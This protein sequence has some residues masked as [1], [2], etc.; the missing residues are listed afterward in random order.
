MLLGSDCHSH[1]ARVCSAQRIWG[2]RCHNKVVL[3]AWVFFCG[4]H[5]G[6]SGVVRTWLGFAVI[7]VICICVSMVLVKHA[8]V[9]KHGM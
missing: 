4:R 1:V 8:I 7:A 2:C 6:V 9:V 3:A 5:I